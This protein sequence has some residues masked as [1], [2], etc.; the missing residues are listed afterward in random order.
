MIVQHNNTTS[1]S[2]NSANSATSANTMAPMDNSTNTTSNP[3]VYLQQE[4]SQPVNTDYS[5]N[6]DHI[7]NLNIINTDRTAIQFIDYF[8]IGTVNIQSGFS[9][10]KS[11][12]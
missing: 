8:K 7:T 3:H 10:K 9:K 2:A 6:E 5:M 4:P 11:S 1:T 12:I